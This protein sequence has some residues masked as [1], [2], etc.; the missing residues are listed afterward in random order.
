[1]RLHGLTRLTEC[2]VELK[3]DIRFLL[4]VADFI[5]FCASIDQIPSLDIKEL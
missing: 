1:M 5:L 2:C 4:L 3:Q